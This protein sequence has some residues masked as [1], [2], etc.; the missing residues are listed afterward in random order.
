MLINGTFVGFS[1][2][3]VGIFAGFIVNTPINKR[4]GNIETYFEED[5]FNSFLIT[6]RSLLLNRWLHHVHPHWSSHPPVLDR[7]RWRK[8]HWSLW[9]RPQISWLRQG[10][11]GYHQ[12]CHLRHRCLL[13]LQGLRCLC[14]QLHSYCQILEES[15]PLNCFT[16]LELH[17]FIRST[18]SVDFFYKL[19]F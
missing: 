18:L 2:I 3:L 9:Q 1:V 12:R 7:Q 13:H 16:P 10:H 4:I 17:Q 15:H 14:M 6:Y 11:T 5:R 8:A 19:Y